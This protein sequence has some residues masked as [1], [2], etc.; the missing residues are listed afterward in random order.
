[1]TPGYWQDRRGLAHDEGRHSVPQVD[2][3]KCWDEGRLRP[4]A[5]SEDP[6]G[7]WHRGQHPGCVTCA[8]WREEHKPPAYLKDSV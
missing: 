6:D 7:L 3:R 8:T 2:C 4:P 5:E 1:M